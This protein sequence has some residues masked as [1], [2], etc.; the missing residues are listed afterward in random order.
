M[1]LYTS[2]ATVYNWFNEFKRGRTNLTDDLRQGRPFMAT[3]EDNISAVRLMIKTDKRVTYQQIRTSLSIGMSQVYK[4]LH[5]QL[6][7]SKLS[8]LWIAYNLTEAQK[9]RL[10]IWCRKMMQRFASL[11][12]I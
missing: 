9:L 3:I 2:L 11:Y 10:V 8:T 6:A 5:E 7:A 12:R 1:K 4:I